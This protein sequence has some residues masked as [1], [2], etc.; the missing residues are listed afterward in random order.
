MT[1]NIVCFGV[2]SPFPGH[3]VGAFWQTL[4]AMGYSARQAIDD[5]KIILL[6]GTDSI[7]PEGL[8]IDKILRVSG[9]FDH[10][11]LWEIDAW[12][13]YFESD[14]VAENSILVDPDL[15]FLKDPRPVFDGD[16]DV[17]LTWHEYRTLDHAINAGVIFCRVRRDG[18]AVADFF[19]RCRDELMQLD[20]KYLQWFGDQEA[21]CRAVGHNHLETS[22]LPPP[23]N[24]GT[25]AVAFFPCLHFNYWPSDHEMESDFRKEGKFVVHFKGER[26]QFIFSYFQKFILGQA[27]P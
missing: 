27:R 10:L 20:P 12:I 7:V 14:L 2:P 5:A 17:G 11:M 13:A 19:K 3:P 24:V 6:T 9:R 4:A 23:T 8:G 16:F 22:K 1:T 18:T 15:L 25:T 26:K 21:L